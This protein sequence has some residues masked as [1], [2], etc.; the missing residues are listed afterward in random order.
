[1]EEADIRSGKVREELRKSMERA[2]VKISANRYVATLA[3][4]RFNRTHYA[5][6]ML[7]ARTALQH[8]LRGRDRKLQYYIGLHIADQLQRMDI[9]RKQT[10]TSKVSWCSHQV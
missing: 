5:A 4:Y 8:E 2:V 7:L 10:L 3:T 6:D 9:L 1:V